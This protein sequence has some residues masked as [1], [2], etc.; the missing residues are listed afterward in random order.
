MALLGQVRP[1]R[2]DELAADD[3]FLR[4]LDDLAYGAGLWQGALRDHDATA[5]L[6]VLVR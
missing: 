1:T 6:P 3:S 5:L 4:R 2:L